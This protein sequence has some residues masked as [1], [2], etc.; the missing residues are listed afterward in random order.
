MFALFLLSALGGVVYLMFWMI[1]N[2]G[3]DRIEDQHGLLRMAMPKRAIVADEE[4][5]RP[6]K[7]GDRVIQPPK[8]RM[9]DRGAPVPHPPKPAVDR[10]TAEAAPE[11][12]IIHP[13]HRGRHPRPR[14]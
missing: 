14:P 11:E 7:R 12:T 5:S 6:P 3:A 13:L 4:N 2:D 1:R 10:K 8:G 9:R